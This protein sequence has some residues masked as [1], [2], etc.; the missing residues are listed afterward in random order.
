MLPQ[1]L[2]SA[3]QNH[4][5]RGDIDDRDDDD[6]EHFRHGPMIAES[7]AAITITIPVE[8]FDR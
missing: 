2:L 6:D 5:D 3:S 1:E 8:W 7:L 4:D